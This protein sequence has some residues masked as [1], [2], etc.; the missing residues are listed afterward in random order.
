M[1]A[2]TVRNLPPDV[3]KAIRRK[4]REERLSLNQVVIKLL[5]EATGTTRKPS[6]RLVHHDLDRFFGTW[7]SEEADAFDQALRKQRQ[8]DPEMWN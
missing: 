3:A 6:K 2:I 5:E 4:A 1:N 8:I 7:T